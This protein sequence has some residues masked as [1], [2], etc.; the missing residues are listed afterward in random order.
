MIILDRLYFV[1]TLF[2]VLLGFFRFKSHNT[3]FKILILLLSFSFIIEVAA[4]F[5]AIKR[6]NNMP[7]YHL[8]SII[9]YLCLTTI[10]FKILR[11]W[12]KKAII[13]AAIPMLIFALFNSFYLQ[14]LN[15]FPSNFL[16]I[17]ELIYIFYAISGFRQMLHTTETALQ[18]QGVFWLNLALII[19]ST[20][21]FIN[22]GLTNYLNEHHVN[23][24]PL[25]IF[26][27]IINL[28]Y[29]ALL[30]TAIAKDLNVTEASKL[31]EKYQQ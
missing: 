17:C 20:T 31:N 8:Y 7:L 24:D 22:F 19:F 18:K 9:E 12:V 5:M 1:F 6:H 13:T 14:G 23:Q 29:I 11:G 25:I 15:H 21:L 26:T 16:L 10:Y 28:I 30:A 27:N 4:K 3:E 2:A